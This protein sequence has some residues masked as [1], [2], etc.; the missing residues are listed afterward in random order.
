MKNILKNRPGSKPAL[1]VEDNLDHLQLLQ[2]ELKSFGWDSIAAV[3]GREALEKVRE[4][5]PRFILLDLMI[6][7]ISGIEVLRILKSD[8]T[9]RKI[10]IL[11]V[12]ALAAADIREKC[13]S[14][15]CDDF[16][17]KPFTRQDLETRLRRIVS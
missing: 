17:L 2:M 4:R 14:A 8:P 5:E 16:L 12:T 7:Q 6:P 15:G 9:Y 13:L 11:V 10:P 3:D 1:I